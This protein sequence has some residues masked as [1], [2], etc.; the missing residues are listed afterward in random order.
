MAEG[1]RHLTV[2]E[3]RREG[4]PDVFCERGADL[5]DEL[6]ITRLE[7]A[8]VLLAAGALDGD[9]ASLHGRADQV[10]LSEL[11]DG[12][13]A[14]LDHVRS[15]LSGPEEGGEEDHL[16]LTIFEHEAQPFRL[17]PSLF[18]Q[19]ILVA[20]VRLVSV[21]VELDDAIRNRIDL[22]LLVRHP[23]SPLGR[24]SARIGQDHFPA[25]I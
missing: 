14:A 7:R 13:L 3:V 11:T 20:A 10:D 24:I 18:A 15:R 8:H 17:V 23:L 19:H 21:T 16:V 6:R 22:A 4:L 9:P 2:F 5:G 1:E 25:L 12:E